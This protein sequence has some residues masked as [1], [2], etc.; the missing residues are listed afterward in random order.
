MI[1]PLNSDTSSINKYMLVDYCFSSFDFEV[2]YFAS[3]AVI[4]R[5]KTTRKQTKQ[6]EMVFFELTM[7]ICL[8]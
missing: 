5:K 6:S 1:G 4:P 2:Y 3:T 7:E 8:V